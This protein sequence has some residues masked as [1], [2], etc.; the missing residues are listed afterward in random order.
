VGRF[1]LKLVPFGAP[2]AELSVLPLHPIGDTLDVW[3]RHFCDLD[4]PDP[5]RD[6][7]E[8]GDVDADFVLNYALREDL[9]ALLD[10]GGPLEVPRIPDNWRRGGDV[11]GKPHQCMGSLSNA[12]SF[13]A[14][15][16]L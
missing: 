4:E 15:Q 7:P 13:S 1:A 6:L 12:L 14:P 11:A 9:Q 10:Q 8:P 2:P 3:V 16:G 5:D